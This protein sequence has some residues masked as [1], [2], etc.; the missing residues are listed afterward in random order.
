MSV[1]DKFPQNVAIVPDGN[2]R[3]AKARGLSVIEGHRAGAQRMHEIVEALIEKAVPYLTVWGFSTDNWKRTDSEVND[4][5]HLLAAWIETDTFWLNSRDVRLRHIG[6]LHELP[7]YLQQVINKAVK[8]TENNTGLTLSLA[9]NYTGRTEIVDAANRLLESPHPVRLDEE[10][11]RH[12]LYTDGI[13]DVDL[14]I[15]TAGDFRLSNFLIWQTA[16]SEL[17]FTEAFW[18]DF[19]TQELEKALQVYSERQR[20]FGGD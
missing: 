14:V 11:F 18:P 3:W 9:F 6:R 15:R 7:D 4:L 20:R 16:Y 12:Y 8:L 10:V 2:R 5:L 17:F 1:V 19:N 13:P